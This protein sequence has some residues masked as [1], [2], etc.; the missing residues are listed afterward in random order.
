MQTATV[1]AFG[2]TVSLDHVRKALSSLR[3]FRAVSDRQDTF[4]ECD[5]DDIQQ[6]LELAEADLVAL[7][8]DRGT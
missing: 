6:T 4:L 8:A 1:V 5:L 3:E 7:I 2:P